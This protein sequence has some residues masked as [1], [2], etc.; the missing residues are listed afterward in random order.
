MSPSPFSYLFWLPH[1]IYAILLY[2]CVLVSTLNPFQKRWVEIIN[3]ISIFIRSLEV[4]KHL[5]SVTANLI[6]PYLGGQGHGSRAEQGLRAHGEALGG[7]SGEET[8]QAE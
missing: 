5:I 6:N 8:P 3:T 7:G 2:M 1:L 4:G